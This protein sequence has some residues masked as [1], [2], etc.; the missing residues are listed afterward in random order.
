MSRLPTLTIFFT[1]SLTFFVSCIAG[2]P[3]K[4][5]GYKYRVAKTTLDSVMWQIIKSDTN[6]IKVGNNRDYLND[7]EFRIH[8]YIFKD[9]EEYDYTFGY[10]GMADDQTRSKELEI[11]LIYAFDQNSKGGT[12]G[13]GDFKG[14]SVL[15]NKLLG[16]FE[17]QFIWK[18]DSMLNQKH[19]DVYP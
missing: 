7:S 18:I 10:V 4:I 11:A 19:H 17:S 15:K 5:M 8:F 14:E 13:Y 3:G 1:L 2:G 16:V 9:N 6:N 12:E